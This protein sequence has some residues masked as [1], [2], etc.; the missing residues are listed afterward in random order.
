MS[1]VNHMRL[2]CTNIREHDRFATLLEA[3]SS[4]AVHDGASGLPNLGTMHME[5]LLK[6]DRLLPGICTS[7]GILLQIWALSIVLPTYEDIR[8]HES[9]LPRGETRLQFLTIV[10]R[11]LDFVEADTILHFIGQQNALQGL[12]LDLARH[13]SAYLGA[14]EIYVK[15]I[16]AFCYGCCGS[17]YLPVLHNIKIV[18]SDSRSTDFVESLMQ[19]ELN[20]LTF[21][22][23][24]RH[25]C[26]EVVR[27]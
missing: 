18:F 4:P 7:P 2:E 1:L 23:R 6:A 17:D 11:P 9:I 26:V 16:V 25:V 14:Y 20:K 19:R 3:L 8:N 21:T 10:Y 13:F 27:A 5:P 15:T 22:N 24:G 12:K